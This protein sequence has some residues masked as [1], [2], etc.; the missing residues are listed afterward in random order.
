MQV[1]DIIESFP[2]HEGEI[3]DKSKIPKPTYMKMAL[4]QAYGAK[5]TDDDGYKV[6]DEIIKKQLYSRDMASYTTSLV[7]PKRV[8]P[9]YSPKSTNTR[10]ELMQ[11]MYEYHM[12]NSYHRLK[13]FAELPSNRDVEFL[14]NLFHIKQEVVK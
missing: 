5:T 6:I 14:K 1:L 13:N 7:E 8:P 9:M 2:Q 10:I 11:E 4:A 3:D 12:N